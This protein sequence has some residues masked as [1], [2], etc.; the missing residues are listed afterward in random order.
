MTPD[1]FAQLR[2]I[3]KR[4]E[5]LRLKPYTDSVNRLSIGYG[6]NLTDVG[7]S[8]SEANE[9]LENDL[10]R[11]IMDLQKAFQFVLELDGP[12]QVVLASMA[13]NLG[14]GGL[15]KFSKMWA[16]IRAKDYAAASVAM[17][18]SHWAEQVGHRAERLAAMMERGTFDTN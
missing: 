14:I 3:V 10:M 7:I 13:F 16:A 8:Q 17:L 11:A 6:R 12:R 1:H 18:D 15:A 5:G 9:L 2:M 4:D